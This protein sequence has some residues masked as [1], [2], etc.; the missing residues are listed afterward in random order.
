MPFLSLDKS[1]DILN[2]AVCSNS[3][4]DVNPAVCQWNVDDWVVVKFPIDDNPNLERRYIGQILSIDA[5][6]NSYRVE[7]LHPK[8]TKKESGY[9]YTYPNVRDDNNDCDLSQLLYK[10][11]NPTKFQRA[12]KFAVHQKDL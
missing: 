6:Q 8:M 10:I 5:E 11:E 4:N 3:I 12:F 1:T 7:S 9:I 2:L